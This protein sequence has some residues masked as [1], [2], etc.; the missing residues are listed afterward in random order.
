MISNSWNGLRPSTVGAGYLTTGS[1]V[2]WSGQL[3]MATGTG[4]Q[5]ST[6]FSYNGNIWYPQNNS[7]VT[8]VSTGYAIAY[9][10]YFTNKMVLDNAGATGTQTID[11]IPDLYYQSSLNQINYQFTFTNQ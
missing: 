8:G 2:T 4:T 3:W 10:N 5:S 9:S 6:V 11:I 7:V 1:A